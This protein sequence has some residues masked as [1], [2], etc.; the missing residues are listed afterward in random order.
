MLYYYIKMSVLLDE[1]ACKQGKTDLILHEE[2]LHPTFRT[3]HLRKHVFL[4]LQLKE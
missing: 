3:G 4:N 2:I 1:Y